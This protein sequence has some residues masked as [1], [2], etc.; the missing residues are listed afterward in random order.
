MQRRAD[1]IY[2][3]QRVMDVIRRYVAEHDYPPSRQEIADQ[4]GWH[5]TSVQRAIARLHEQG[6]IEV[7]EGGSSRRRIRIVRA[8]TKALMEDL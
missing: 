4:L 2:N 1:S 5:Y 6:L 3:E 7:G 8:N